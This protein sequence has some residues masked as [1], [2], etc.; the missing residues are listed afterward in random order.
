MCSISSSNIWNQYSYSAHPQ[1]NIRYLT[2][3]R[4]QML[5][6]S[7]FSSLPTPAPLILSPLFR[8]TEPSN[9]MELKHMTLT[10]KYQGNVALSLYKAKHIPF[11]EL[12]FW[13]VYCLNILCS[14]K[15]CW[16]KGMFSI[17]HSHSFLGNLVSWQP[18][19][20]Q[21]CLEVLLSHEI[22]SWKITSLTFFPV[23]REGLIL[24]TY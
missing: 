18:L 11:K 19:G 4:G 16:W 17:S 2:S 23:E 9:P 24:I 5:L 1:G 20:L 12:S 22:W 14:L 8:N 7:S 21:N 10:K 15:W 6:M 13:L 3:T